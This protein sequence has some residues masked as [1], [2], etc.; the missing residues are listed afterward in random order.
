M[1][2][3]YKNLNI[4]IAQLKINLF[5]NIYNYI[6]CIFV[7]MSKYVLFKISDENDIMY[8]CRKC[9]DKDDTIINNKE[10]FGFKDT[11]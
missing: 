10:V 11:Y 1:I 4:L 2:I 8:Y 6:K 9:G 5:K 7:S 3:L